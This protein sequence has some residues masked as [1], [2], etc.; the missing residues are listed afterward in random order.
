MPLYIRIVR[1]REMVA[2]PLDSQQN[3]AT[4]SSGIKTILP[5]VSAAALEGFQFSVKVPERITHRKKLSIRQ[6]AFD[7][8]EKYLDMLEPLKTYN[9]LGAILC[10]PLP[11]A[12]LL[13]GR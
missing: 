1:L 9:K 5:R 8:F 6:G 13:Y 12:T 2:L 7:D 11:A 10:Y 4:C 3:H